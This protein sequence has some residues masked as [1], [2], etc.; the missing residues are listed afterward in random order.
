M[1]L[2]TL[3]DENSESV[4]VNANGDFKSPT[5]QEIQQQKKSKFQFGNLKPEATKM[6]DEKNNSEIDR[7]KAINE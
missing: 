1:A 4:Q 7:I 6:P 5:M 2:D 3:E